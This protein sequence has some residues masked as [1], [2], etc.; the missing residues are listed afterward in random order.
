MKKIRFCLLIFT[1]LTALPSYAVSL[2]VQPKAGQWQVTTQTFADGKDIGSKLTLIKQ[3]AAAFLNPQQLEKLAR[4]DPS[5]FTECL[6]SKQAAVL[7]D[8]KKSLEMMSRAFGQCQLQIDNQDSAQSR[9]HFSGYC[10]ASK[11]GVE[12][13]VEGQIHYQSAT[14]VVG[15]VDGLGTLPQAIQLLLLGRLQPQIHLRNNFTAQWQQAQCTP[16]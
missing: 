4:Y 11:Y 13:V 6:S 15:F 9:L 2:T 16:Q 7:V 1:V 8:P 5:E 3:Q 10:N 14:Q 12:G